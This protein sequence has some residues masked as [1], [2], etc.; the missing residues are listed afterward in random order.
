M[1]EVRQKTTV[2]Q[3]LSASCPS[4][5]RS[6]VATRD[7]ESVIDEPGERGGSNLGFT[8]TETAM[9]ALIGCTN[10]ISRRIAHGIGMEF[11]DVTIDLEGD[12][13]RRGVML[14]EE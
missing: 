12:F 11:E 6:D 14:A 3:K 10:V 8:P 13:D 4:H 2:T 9:A 7:L 1:A 5:T